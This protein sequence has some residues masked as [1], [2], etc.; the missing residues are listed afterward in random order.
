LPASQV[1]TVDGVT[2][3]GVTSRAVGVVEPGAEFN[4]GLLVL[5]HMVLGGRLADPTG[6]EQEDDSHEGRDD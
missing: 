5:A 3:L 1:D 2:R 4:V 6:Q